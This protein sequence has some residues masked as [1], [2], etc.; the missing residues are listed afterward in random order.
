MIARMTSRAAWSAVGLAITA[1]CGS[2]VVVWL[3]AASVPHSG[4]PTW[5]AVVLGII[6][7]S[8]VYFAVAAL[9]RWWPMGGYRSVTEMLD[10]RI[11]TGR[12]VRQL[13]FTHEDHVEA[14]RI[15]TD[16]FAATADALQEHFPA[17]LDQFMLASG[18]QEHF[19][20]SALV[21]SL[22]NARLSVLTRVR[23][24]TD[25]SGP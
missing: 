9:A 17:I 25:E 21:G 3:G 15:A 24:G 7:A 1:C 8:G 6:T 14:G 2:S 12:Q 20:G 19:S 10:D 13:V 16:W 22:M 11:R 18:D 5:P 23:L 4:L